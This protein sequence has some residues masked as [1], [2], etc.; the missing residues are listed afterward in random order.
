MNCLEWNSRGLGN[1]AAVHEL[2]NIVKQERPSLLYV[3]ETKI[4]AKRV[5]SLKESLGFAGC[6]A[7]NSDGLSGGI[8][9]FW[10][11]DVSVEVKKFSFCH[12]DTMVRKIDSPELQWRWTGFYGAPRAEDR[13]H[14]W[15]S[16]R[17]LHWIEHSAWL[18][19]GDFN[20]TLYASEHFSRALRPEWQMRAFREVLE[21]CSLVDLGWSGVEYTWD[22]GQM[23]VANV[24][25]R[26][27]RSLG[28]EAFMNMFA[29][30][31]VRHIVTSESDHCF[32]LSEVRVDVG[33]TRPRGPIQFRYEDVWQT[34]A[35]YDDL[36]LAKWK[37][38]AGRDGLSGV[39]QALNDMQAS[40]SM[41]GAKEFG[42]L[43]RKVRKLRQK[44]ERLRGCSVGRGPTDE[45]RAV[46][47]QLREAL[48]QEEIWMRQRSRVLWLREG[49]RNT[50]YFHRHA[51]HRKRIN[52]VENLARDDGS[53]CDN[54]TDVCTEVQS[55]YQN[56]YTSQGFNHMDEL[57]DLVP[58]RVNQDMNTELDKTFSV[59][60]VRAALFQ[61]APSKAP[62][63]DGFTAGFFQRHW[64][65]LKDDIVPAVLDF[66]NGGELPVDQ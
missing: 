17:T 66:L 18:C 32:V 11:A 49:D 42:C 2:R 1:Q 45:E 26:L 44:L 34:H 6:F 56:L 39:V 28:N 16:L 20:E 43:A 10:S 55:F 15:R 37:K 13:H 35:D 7:V 64:N 12:I 40:L 47:K 54:W 27:D 4:S 30:K 33:D 52:K 25:A 38:G 3:M 31:R 65:L 57:L 60:E 63:V 51:A 46:V 5:E 59:E 53:I 50:A 9:V 29:H 24:K 62:G 36:V 61:M 8:G 58:T 23:G 41:W 48:R 21:D 14:S 22:N 19:V